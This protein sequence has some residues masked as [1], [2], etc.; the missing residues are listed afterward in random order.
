MSWRHSPSSTVITIARGRRTHLERQRE[1]LHR[2]VPRVEHVIVDMGGELIEA[3]DSIVAE[4]P[5]SDGVPLP[6]AR[7]RN[8]GA[9]HATTAVLIFLDVDCIPSPGLADEYA[10]AVCTHDALWSG[11]VGYL[12]PSETITDWSEGALAQV[13]HFHDGRPRPGLGAG[14]S[15]R[16]EM[17]WSL[18]F[19]LS[20]RTWNAIGG[21]DERFVGYGGEDTDFARTAH[22]IGVELWF[23]GAAV[24]FHQ[25]HP[26]NSPPVQHLDDIVRNARVFY[27]KWGAWPM[28]GWLEVFARRGLVDWC[29]T[30]G[31][32]A[33]SDPAERPS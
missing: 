26:T 16:W 3:E 7:A 30:S 29:P 18:S 9:A 14:R 24:A 27:E 21:F 10:R 13:G 17:F 6:L 20:R 12:P 28:R 8:L 19:A 4:C 2:L 32:L 22:E 1:A 25:H 5:V 15:D 23:T 31:R 33:V 11:P